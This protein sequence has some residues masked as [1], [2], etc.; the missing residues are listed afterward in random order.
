MTHKK[1]FIIAFFFFTCS[2]FAQNKNATP[3]VAPIVNKT[4]QKYN[5]LSSFSID[6]KMIIEKEKKTAQRI[7][8]VLLIK[9]D[10]YFLT[11]ND[12]IIANDG[13]VAWNYQKT[14]NEVALFDA[15]DA[16]FEIFNPIKMLNNWNKEYDAKFI[17]EEE[18]QKKQIIIVD[19]KPKKESDFYKIRLFIDKNSSYIQQIMMYE[20]DN[21]TLTYKFT[22][23]IPNAAAADT[24]F[25]FIKNDYPNVQ[26]NDMR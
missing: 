3:Q 17:R 23:F 4:V 25:N 8:G 11:F 22:K 19:L 9:K 21:T 10:K 20:P 24:K 1:F 7:E 5:A 12:Q 2:L 15:Q 16:D 14:T 6:F 26:I 18:M 13:K